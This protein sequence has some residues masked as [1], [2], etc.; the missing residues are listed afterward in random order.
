[1]CQKKTAKIDL[2][3]IL[4][5]SHLEAKKK[6]NEEGQDNGNR[7]ETGKEGDT[8]GRADTDVALQEKRREREG[9]VRM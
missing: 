3:H 7:E 2:I 9:R 6:K 5:Q 8:A 4:C 1:M